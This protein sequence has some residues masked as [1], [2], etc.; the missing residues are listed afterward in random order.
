MRIRAVYFANSSSNG[1]KCVIM[2]DVKSINTDDL[3]RA[4]LQPWDHAMAAYEREAA[5]MGVPAHRVLNLLLNHM[6]S[7]VAMIDPPQ[8]RELL[9]EDLVKAFAPMVRQHIDARF[10][11]PGGVFLPGGAV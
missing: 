2:A 10:K 5:K 7:V 4:I 3:G 9:I 1:S 8:A 11:S 6:A